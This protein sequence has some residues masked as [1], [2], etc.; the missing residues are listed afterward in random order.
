MKNRFEP[1]C[2]NQQFRILTRPDTNWAGRLEAGNCGYKKKRDCTIH[3]A[4][5]KVQ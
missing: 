4:K 5:L 2:E 3:V 1:L